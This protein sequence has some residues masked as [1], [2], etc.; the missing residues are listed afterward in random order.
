MVD[1]PERP[2]E[3]SSERPESGSHGSSTVFEGLWQSSPETLRAALALLPTPTFALDAD[4]RIIAWNPAIER[5]CGVSADAMLGRSDYAHA[6]VFYGERRAALIDVVA[7]GK[8]P[9]EC[10]YDAS[11]HGNTLVA[12]LHLPGVNEGR[13]AHVLA[14]A[15]AF[16]DESG[17]FLGAIESLHDITARV[18]VEQALRERVALESALHTT[19][20]RLL[21]AD[22]ETLAEEIEAGLG[23]VAALLGVD[24]AYIF[25]LDERSAEMSNTHEWCAVGIEP[26]IAQLQKVPFE[27][28]RWWL[29]TLREKREL[30]LFDLEEIPER[31]TNEKEILSAQGILSLAVF[32][33]NWRGQELGFVGFDAVAEKRQWSAEDLR[34]LKSLAALF[35]NAL[36]H[37]DQTRETSR[38][39]AELH[40]S[41]KLESIGRLAGGVAH[42]FNNLLTGILGY[43]ELVEEGLGPESPYASD[44]REIRRAGERAAALTQQLLAFSRRQELER[45]SLDLPE[46]VERARS[47]LTR[48]LGEDVRLEFRLE[49]APL[50]HAD[51]Q[52]LEQLLLNLAV[53]ARDAMPR[54]GTITI[55]VD[56]WELRPGRT[57]LTE[58]ADGRYARL[59][60]RD[61]GTGM[62]EEVRQRAFDPFF[63]TKAAG[64]GTGLGLSMAYG[65]AN[66]AGGSISLESAPGQGTTVSLLLPATEA[67]ASS[68]P[69]LATLP[70]VRLD[71]RVL[72]VEDDVV[73][74][75]LVARLLLARGLDV[76]QAGSAEEALRLFART[77]NQFDLLVTD[78]VLPGLDGVA[79]YDAARTRQPLLR[80]LYLS[81]YDERTATLR[82]ALAPG[83]PLLE[84]PFSSAEIVSRVVKLLA[85]P[86]PGRAEEPGER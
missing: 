51:E 84:K 38:L 78:I 75:R 28:A 52:Q 29:E 44:V 25:R 49:R 61:T 15:R 11:W 55:S 14:S 8:D 23:R 19:A 50:V 82:S 39:E 1:H 85:S 40:H 13:G 34:I 76:E 2:P 63:T 26:Q 86:D 67:K 20:E 81:G 24:R 68:A 33:L 42:D 22:A 31:G 3:R 21:L 83:T 79:L 69:P 72:V 43:T 5:L 77:D 74:R 6:E 60:V 7:H 9:V 4:H 58:L 16:R 73:V 53:N 59:R 56:A 46:L 41:L 18:G 48:V 65:V 12:Q 37:Q 30:V 32:S 45:S 10:G 70:K 57:T 54:G 80:A 64:K 35:T 36:V 66:D 47:L 71:G 17:A 62:S 27:M